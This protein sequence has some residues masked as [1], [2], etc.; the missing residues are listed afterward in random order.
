[1][2][3]TYTAEIHVCYVRELHLGDRVTVSWQLLDHD[4]KRLHSFLELHHSDG[5]LAATCESMTL[6]IDMEGP[7]VAPFPPD[8]MEKVERV[9]AVHASLPR[10][11]RAGR[12]IAIRRRD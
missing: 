8:V 7:K 12:A 1:R 11:E 10:P 2:L 5:W 4:E 6:H 3:T 9:Q